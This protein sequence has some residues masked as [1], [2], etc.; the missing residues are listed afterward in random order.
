MNVFPLLKPALSN[1]YEK[2]SGKDETY[3]GIFLNQAV[4]RDLNWFLEHLS[5]SSGVHL[6]E[7]SI[8]ELKEAD[9]VIYCDASLDGLGFYYPSLSTGYKSRPPSHTPPRNILYLEAFCIC[10]ALHHAEHEGFHG[11]LLIFTDSEN[12][13][14]I[15]NTL[16]AKPIY[17][18]IVKSTVDILA[19]RQIDL[20]VTWIDGKS[21]IVA[22][23]LSR[24][25]DNV[26][27]EA[28]PNLRID[29]FPIPAIR[30]PP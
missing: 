13:Y 14:N 22:D 24:W 28:C 25:K 15:F 2:I 4:I 11:K 10:W 3:A 18:E 26:A 29:S 6:L 27:I 21:N 12:S 8:W 19:R 9:L 5:R 16:R 20:R 23:A 1:V 17:N 7:T 30:P